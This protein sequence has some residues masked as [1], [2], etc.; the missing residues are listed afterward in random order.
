MEGARAMN[1]RGENLKLRE[2]CCCARESCDAVPR[3]TAGLFRR[4]SLRRENSGN[5]RTQSIGIH[6]QFAMG[7]PHALS[8]SP[9]PDAHPATL[10]L[11]LRES[12]WR[13]SLPMILNLCINL[14]GLTSDTDYR[15]FAS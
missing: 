8:H 3:N 13:H 15:G 6:I 7:L 4:G 9:N 12:F 2:F 11:N 5:R 14:V 10:G 1:V